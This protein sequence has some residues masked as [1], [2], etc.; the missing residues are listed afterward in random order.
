MADK[1]ARAENREP[2]P[3]GITRQEWAALKDDLIELERHGALSGIRAIVAERLSM[4]REGS[5]ARAGLES[6]LRRRADLARDAALLAAE[7]DA[8]EAP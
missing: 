3:P 2:L 5:T 8:R 6:V 7:I 4:A 1:H